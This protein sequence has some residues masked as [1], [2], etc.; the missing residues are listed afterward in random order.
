[1]DIL[2][3]TVYQYYVDRR[4]T[5]SIKLGIILILFCSIGKNM[6]FSQKKSEPNGRIIVHFFLVQLAKYSE[7]FSRFFLGPQMAMETHFSDSGRL[8]YWSIE[9][10]GKSPYTGI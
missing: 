5:Y 8:I 3:A 9:E 2:Q 4:K 6:I 7:I 10:P 1:M